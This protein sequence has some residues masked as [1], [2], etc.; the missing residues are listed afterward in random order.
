MEKLIKLSQVIF[1]ELTDS[2]TIESLEEL[3]P[4][5]GLKEGA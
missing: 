1:P 5:R 2:D 3:F 4:E